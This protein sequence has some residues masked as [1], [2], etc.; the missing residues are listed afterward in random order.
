MRT[1]YSLIRPSSIAPTSQQHLTLHHCRPPTY[2]SERK[3][4]TQRTQPYRAI[5]QQARSSK[6]PTTILTQPPHHITPHATTT[7]PST[8]V[9]KTKGKNSQ[10]HPHQRNRHSPRH[11]RRLIE[12]EPEILALGPEHQRPCAGPHGQQQDLGCDFAESDDGV[13]G[14]GRRDEGRSG[15]GVGVVAVESQDVV[16]EGH[17]G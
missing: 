10:L 9:I 2:P 4:T 6:P 1:I 11:V 17:G 14:E 8:A 16:E 12:Q 3:H 13:G 7:P 5:R 15:G